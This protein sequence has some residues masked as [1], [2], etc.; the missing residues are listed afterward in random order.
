MKEFYLLVLIFILEQI[1]CQSD[2]TS[3]AC[4]KIIPT[5]NSDCFK[6]SY[7]NNRCCYLSISDINYNKE[8]CEIVNNSTTILTVDTLD[9]Q[10][11][12]GLS[13]TNT[14]AYLDLL[15]CGKSNPLTV[16]DCTKN[17]NITTSCCWTYFGGLNYCYGI[18]SEF[19]LSETSYNGLS[20]YCFEIFLS[21]S[22]LF[23][24]FVILIV[25]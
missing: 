14:S 23:I 4:A 22:L 3:P 24:Y 15:Q 18:N 5:V 6:A 13:Q 21:N 25:I 10:V 9:Y 11:D 1:L 12:C 19:V 20:F 8:I 16:S 2:T 17:S 7:T